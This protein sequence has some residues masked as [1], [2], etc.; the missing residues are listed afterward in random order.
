VR[1][2]ILPNVT[3]PARYEGNELGAV[4]KD[5]AEAEASLLLAF[6]DVYEVGMSYLGFKILYDVVNARK[7]WVAERAFAPWPDMEQEMR[8]HAVPLYGLETFTPAREFDV[9]GFTLQYELTYTNVLMMLGLAGIPLRS[10][11]RG[12]DDP[13]IIAGGPCAVNPEPVAAFFDL[14]VVGDGEEVITEIMDVVARARHARTPR[15]ELIRE[16][17]SL[18]GV[19]CPELGNPVR[20]RV[21]ADLEGAAFPRKFIVPFMELVHDRVALE[22]MRGCSRGCRFCQAGVLYRPV[23]ERSVSNLCELADALL[24]SSGYEEVSLLSLSTADYSGVAQLVRNLVEKYG[25][26]GV[27]V[28]L[29]SLRVDSFS[30]ALAREV[31]KSRRT[32]LTFAP[33]AGTQRLRDIINKGVTEEDLMSAVTDAFESGWENVKLYFMIGLPHETYEDI[34]GIADLSKKV[35]SAGRRIAAGRGKAG[36]VGVNVSV[37][38]FVPK[39]HTPFQWFGQNT[40]EE[41]K[42]KQHYLRDRLR[43]RG[44]SVSFPDVRAS[45]LEATFA[46]GDRSLCPVVERAV[47]LGCRFD[48]WSELF[49]PDLWEQAFAEEGVDSSAHATRVFAPDEPLPWDYIDMGV[50]KGFLLREAERAARG[51]LTPDCREGPCSRCGVCGGDVRVRLLGKEAG[52]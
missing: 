39:P 30:I 26:E 42:A 45:H 14:V 18:P 17:A 7:E 40:T 52:A 34:G 3:R 33:E 46:R 2:E 24:S 49:R 36:R 48:G 50:A 51:E 38:S 1:T 25:H 21:V 8:A 10:R 28:S 5:H 44:I 43:V 32:G 29:P 22:V 27:A 13:V 19:H 47:R 31:Q 6:P 11:D 16:L 41:L 4:R 20:R 12:E 9:I 23:R 35:L 37:S 15:R